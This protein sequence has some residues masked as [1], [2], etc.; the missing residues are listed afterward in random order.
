MAPVPGRR[1]RPWT[2]IEEGPALP[3]RHE[4][5]PDSGEGLNGRSVETVAGDRDASPGLRGLQQRRSRL[6][7]RQG[8]GGG[9][10]GAMTAGGVRRAGILVRSGCIRIRIRG[11]MVM[12]PALMMLVSERGVRGRIGEH[13]RGL[14]RAEGGGGSGAGCP[15]KK[16]E[17]LRVP[18]QGQGQHDQHQQQFAQ[19]GQNTV[20]GESVSQW[21]D[22]RPAAMYCGRII[23]RL[24][25]EPGATIRRTGPQAL[26]QRLR[27][28][29][30]STTAVRQAM[31]ARMR[32]ITR[33]LVARHHP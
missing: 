3:A 18:L 25:P 27:R 10:R 28:R 31:L 4:G 19:G 33:S 8:R 30:P 5:W 29:C 21:P 12:G 7:T 6:W 32:A 11:V 9:D 16:P 1:A 13:G 2:S 20:S 17:G 24:A 26:R 23:V 14:G 22:L 15:A